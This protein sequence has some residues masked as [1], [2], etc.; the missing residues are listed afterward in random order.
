MPN[1]NT[2]R[3]QTGSA[4]AGTT[5]GPATPFP[6]LWDPANAWEAQTQFWNQLVELSR[7]FWSVYT[8]P[9]QAMPWL[10]NTAP[11]LAAAEV[12]VEPVAASDAASDALESQTRFWNHFLDAQRS[13]WSS[14]AW[15]LPETPWAGAGADSPAAAHNV[16]VAVAPARARKT[17]SAVKRAKP[18]TAK[19]KAGR[20]H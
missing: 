1:W 11:P 12:M 16:D 2:L 8:T 4:G 19:R 17:P 6:A 3:P 10:L 5:H 14:Y 9:L 7:S 15:T 20:P 18:G 13:F